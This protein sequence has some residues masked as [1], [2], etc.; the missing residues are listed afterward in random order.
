MVTLIWKG[1]GRPSWRKERLEK[2]G[3]PRKDRSQKKEG[4]LETDLRG[5]V[6]AQGGIGVEDSYFQ[7]RNKT[8]AGFVV[9]RS[10]L[11]SLHYPV[12]DISASGS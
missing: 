3:E 11:A 10:V 5:L 8:S 4:S 2:G 7:R 9:H 12:N 6:K 1:L